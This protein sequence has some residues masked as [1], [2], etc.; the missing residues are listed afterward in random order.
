M[1]TQDDTLDLKTLSVHGGGPW[2]CPV[3]PVV[4][5]IVAASAFEFD[6]MAQFDAVVAGRQPGT[7]YARHNDPN[8]ELLERQVARL[9]GGQSAVACGSGMAA[10]TTAVLATLRA[11]DHVVVAHHIY[12]AVHDFFERLCPRW[13]IDVTFVASNAPADYA[14][15]CRD[16]TRVVYIETPS[17]PSLE[18][19]DIAALA[20]VAHRHDAALWVDSTFATPALQRPLALGAD[21]V[22]H[23]AT[24][25]LGGHGD[26]LGGLVVGDEALM[27]TVRD[28]GRK[29]LGSNLSPFAAW[30]IWRGIATLP[31]RMQQISETSLRLARW[32]AEQPNVTAVLYPGLE[33]HPDHAVA[34]KQMSGYG[35]VLSFRLAD[36]RD[37][38]RRVVDRVQLM[39]HAAN[40]GDVRTLLIHYDSLFT[41]D[42]S[43]EELEQRG[44]HA[45]MI[46][47]CVGLEAFE[48]L[49]DD[50][51]QAME[52]AS[53]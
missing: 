43:R 17:N 49:R 16:N 42:V 37:A 7:N 12:M 8:S 50:L 41:P 24:K 25:Y 10:I 53:A 51:A 1:T 14:G 31:L 3:R 4:P 18:I 28:D 34:A 19:V 30:L 21:V 5:P 9:E 52:S 26:A 45:D 6:S 48:D 33:T 15:A 11:G 20:E 46:R 27:Q 36:G 47:V 2:S 32:L 35:G 13:G 22:I 40:L 23:S 38:A 39:R 29:I 44:V